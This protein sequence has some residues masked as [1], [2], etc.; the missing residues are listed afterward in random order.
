MYIDICMDD[1]MLKSAFRE[2]CY[3][4]D[5]N[6]IKK[7]IE[8]FNINETYFKIACELKCFNIVKYLLKLYKYNTNYKK[9]NIHINNLYYTHNNLPIL[10]YLQSI[11]CCIYY[12]CEICVKK[13][14]KSCL[15][16]C[17]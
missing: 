3:Y 6:R 5:F 9:I 11:G 10:Q 7:L 14:N 15:I 2:L 4:D 13:H 17:L 12:H 8:E 16:C 1:E